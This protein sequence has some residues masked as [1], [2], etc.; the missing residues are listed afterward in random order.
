MLVNVL[1]EVSV[2][3]DGGCVVVGG[4]TSTYTMPNKLGFSLSKK[5]NI[6]T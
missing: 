1:V 4:T 2:V 6:P 3:E 5:G